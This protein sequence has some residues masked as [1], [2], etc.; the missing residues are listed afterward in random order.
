MKFCKKP[1]EWSGQELLIYFQVHRSNINGFEKLKKKLFEFQSTVKF[2]TNFS[3][4]FLEKM[5]TSLLHNIQLKHSCRLQSYCF[6]HFMQLKISRGDST[7]K[8]MTMCSGREE[9]K[10]IQ[11]HERRNEQ[12][13]KLKSRAGMMI[14]FFAHRIAIAP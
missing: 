1:R 3:I 7:E 4:S 5:Q 12:K 13:H 11:M 6:R 8:N 14:D 9:E 2:S 10:S